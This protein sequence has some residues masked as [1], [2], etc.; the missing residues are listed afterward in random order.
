M[1]YS[2]RVP[3]LRSTTDR[4][5]AVRPASTEL[6]GVHLDVPNVRQT[7]TYTCGASSAVAVLRALGMPANER[8][9]AKEMGSNNVVGTFATNIV[10]AMKARG[11]S[12]DAKEHLSFDDLK[13]A[14]DKG[15]MVIVAYQAWREDTD[16]EWKKRWDDGHY[17]VVTG[18]D[19]ENI[20]LMDPSQ[21]D[22]GVIPRREFLDRWHDIDGHDTKVIKFGIVIDGAP[23]NL[24]PAAVK[25]PTKVTRVD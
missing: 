20:Y 17:S 2:H 24:R 3:V 21:D 5:H 25:K 1:K 19:A 10:K 11:L 15:A 22:R 13:R 16:V 14:L 18:L 4:V 23:L 9:M 8:A 12:A 7:T 6:R